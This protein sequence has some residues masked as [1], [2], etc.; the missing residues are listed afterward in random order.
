M[1]HRGPDGRRLWVNDQSSVSLAFSPTACYCGLVRLREVQPMSDSSGRI[2]VTFN[3]EIYNYKELRLS[4]ESGGH[5]FQSECDTE[6][7][8]Y[9]YKEYGRG[10][11]EFLDGDFAF[12][13]WDSWKEMLVCTARD[14]MGVKPF[15]YV[16]KD[17]MFYFS[18]ELSAL[19]KSKAVELKLNKNC[20][21]SLPQLPRCTAASPLLEGVWE[22]ARACAD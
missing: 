9:L 5:Q 18:S 4:L 11:V 12:A 14:R 20:S 10:M 8:L 6:V 17:G 1:K 16:E 21:F 13:I 15:Y 7:L 2:H 3:G 19:V 22:V